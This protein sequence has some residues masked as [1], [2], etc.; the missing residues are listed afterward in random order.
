MKKLLLILV[1]ML[2]NHISAQEIKEVEMCDLK[3]ETNS[4]STQMT[5]Y[6]NEKLLSG[7][8]KISG[9]F[10]GQYSI[11]EFI[12]GK[13]EGKAETFYEGARIREK[14]FINGLPNGL[15]I[16]YDDTGKTIMRKIPYSNGIF[17]GIAWSYGNNSE[18]YYWHGRIVSREEYEKNQKN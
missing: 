6:K 18:T 15:W 17:H 7:K 14:Y 4:D 12:N 8:Y 16:E 2:L 9:V 1:L 10:P 5:V 13:A 11:T 3:F